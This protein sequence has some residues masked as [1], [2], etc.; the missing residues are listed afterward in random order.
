[1]IPI[2]V[3]IAMI[4]VS[5]DNPRAARLLKVAGQKQVVVNKND[6]RARVAWE[7]ANGQRIMKEL[8]RKHLERLAE[9][10]TSPNPPNVHGTIIALE[11][12]VLVLRKNINS[13]EL[14]TGNDRSLRSRTGRV[15]CARQEMR[16]QTGKTYACG[17]SA[18]YVFREC[19]NPFYN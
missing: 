1:M 18:V 11:K 7:T 12:L 9:I 17:Y 4:P 13:E 5:M 2:L 3:S 10:R 16:S 15:D 8:D 6:I 19:K 14:E